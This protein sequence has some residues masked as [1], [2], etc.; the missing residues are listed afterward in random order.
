MKKHFGLSVGLC[1]LFTGTFF[2]G[3]ATAIAQ[4]QSSGVTPPPKVLE[5]GVEFTQLG[6]A[7]DAHEKAESKFVQAFSDAKWSEH[8][9]A[10]VAISGTPR[11]VFF[12]GYDSFAAAQENHEAMQKNASLMAALQSA[13]SDDEKLLQSRYSSVFVYDE[14]LSL[15]ASVKIPDMRF[16]EITIFDIRPGHRHDW[17]ELVKIYQQAWSKVPDAHWATFEEQYGPHGDRYIVIS[18]LKSLADVDQELMDDKKMAANLSAD[19]KKKMADLSAS[20]IESEQSNLFAI[21][22]KMSYV[23]DSWKEASPDFWGKK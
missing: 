9:L 14:D 8:Y 19:D 6:L 4:E 13:F 21:S 1:L 5:I 16:F 12:D 17:S 22:P 7:P 15:R 23:P 3:W 20:T 2:A 10:M 11:V 18:P